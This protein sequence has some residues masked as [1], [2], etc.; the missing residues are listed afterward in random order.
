MTPRFYYTEYSTGAICE[1]VSVVL[2]YDVFL[3]SIDECFGFLLFCEGKEV[4]C[5]L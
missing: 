5:S 3:C 2:Y 4:C 1:I